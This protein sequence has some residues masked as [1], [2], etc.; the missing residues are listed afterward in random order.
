[1][2]KSTKGR[3]T[4]IVTINPPHY[5]NNLMDRAIGWF[6]IAKIKYRRSAP[7]KILLWFGSCIILL[8][9]WKK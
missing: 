7:L 1:M 8:E 2:R 5:L 4:A 6:I 3:R 9:T